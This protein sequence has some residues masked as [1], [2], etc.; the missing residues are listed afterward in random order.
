M[1]RA[2]T[3]VVLAGCAS[4]SA[5]LAQQDAPPGGGDDAKVWLDGHAQD[6]DAPV[7]AAPHI[8]ARLDAPP[9]APPDARPVDAPS[10]PVSRR[11]PSCSR[12]RSST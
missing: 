6:P 4:G 7:D 5:P 12:I 3:A 1:K 10:M 2:L 11:P 8:D 9:D